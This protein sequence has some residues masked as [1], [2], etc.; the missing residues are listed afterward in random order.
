MPLCRGPPLT[1][2]RLF[3]VAEKL[4][5]ILAAAEPALRADIVEADSRAATVKQRPTSRRITPAEI[6][7]RG[8]AVPGGEG[9]WRDP[10]N[11]P[12]GAPKVE[13]GGGGKRDRRPAALQAGGGGYSDGVGRGRGSGGGRWGG[14]L[15]SAAGWKSLLLPLQ[16]LFERQGMAAHAGVLAGAEKP[17]VSLRKGIPRTKSVGKARGDRGGVPHPQGVRPSP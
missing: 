16:S 15:L 4:D 8:G 17:H 9:E 14:R 3:G 12:G 10:K 5:E 13:G 6:S 1:A 7:V 11:G 2:A